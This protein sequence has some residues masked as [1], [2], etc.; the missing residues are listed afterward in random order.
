MALKQ[1]NLV[2]EAIKRKN[3]MVQCEI[4][5]IKTQGDVLIKQSLTSFGGK[6]VFVTAIEEALEQ[7]QVDIAVHSAKDLPMELMD[8]MQIISVL[9]REDPRDVLVMRKENVGKQKLIVGSSSLRRSEQIRCLMQNCEIQDIRGNVPTRIQK[10]KEGRYDATI[11]AMAGLKRLSLMQEEEL[12]YRPFEIEEMIPAGC[13]GIIAVE[14]KK[15]H[16]QKAFIEGIGDEITK[17]VFEI[18]RGILQSLGAGC[19]EPVGVVATPKDHSFFVQLYQKKDARTRKVEFEL[20]GGESWEKYILWEPD[21]E[22][23]N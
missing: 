19:H 3:P 13:Q 20:E 12:V 10:V 14:M 21:L 17:Q 2:A 5:V 1:A 11:L 22:I 23:R 16:P 6:G 7:G 18:E 8:G 9:K 15:T 4:V